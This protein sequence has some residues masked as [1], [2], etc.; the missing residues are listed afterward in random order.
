MH[1]GLFCFLPICGVGSAI[2]SDI[3]GAI[4]RAI[5][6]WWASAAAWLLGLVG[7]VLT[8]TTTPPVGTRWFQ[9]EMSVLLRVAAPIALLALVAAAWT[10]VVQGDLSVVL[11]AAL[12]RLPLVVLLSAAGAGLVTT[13]L[14]ATDAVS[15]AI[16]GGSGHTVRTALQLMAQEVL[17]GGPAPAGVALLVAV[18]VVVGALALWLEL[19]VRAAAIT[20]LTA[21]LPL[22]LAA[23]LWPPGVAWARRVA[24]ALGALIAAKVVIVLVLVLGVDA[25]ASSG[26]AALL[27]GAAMLLLASFAPYA[28]VRL[29]PLAESAAVAH[30]EGI[31]HRATAAAVGIPRRAASVVLAAGGGEAGVDAV[32]SD[33]I[34]MAHGEPGDLVAGTSLDPAATFKRGRIPV[35]A[36]PASAGEHVWERDEFGPRLV[37]KPPWHV[38]D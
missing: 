4:L 18:V 16:A 29:V 34:G 14:G 17:S 32:G 31:R 28:V 1:E 36:V 19:V 35:T 13:A 30:L 38:D 7:R 27:T 26:T 6:G 20:V 12:L 8:T 11:R 21:S 9:A 25:L 33:P 2:G 24:E 5:A 15:S 10:A 22:V 23:A 37:W 3:A